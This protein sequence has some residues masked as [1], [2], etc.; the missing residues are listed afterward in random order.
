MNFILNQ[1]L[2][3]FLLII[4]SLAILYFFW[5][6]RE[7]L[8]KIKNATSDI[9]DVLLQWRNASDDL[10]KRDELNSD[11]KDSLI[12]FTHFET[13]KSLFSKK[14][15]LSHI[16][17][18]FDEQLT[19]SEEERC[20]KNSI[21]PYEFF[22]AEKISLN[23]DIDTH[24][25]DG[26][27]S[28]FIGIGIVGTFLGLTI[29]ILNLA[30]SFGQKDLNLVQDGLMRGVQGLLSGAGIAFFTSLLG[31]F[32]SLLFAH[33]KRNCFKD[34]D[35]AVYNLNKDIEKSLKFFTSEQLNEES[36]KSLKRQDKLLA[37]IDEHLNLKLDEAPNKI[38]EKLDPVFRQIQ[39]ALESLSQSGTQIIEKNTE[40]ATFKLEKLIETLSSSIERMSNQ[41]PKS[42]ESLLEGQK[43]F[44]IQINDSLKKI[45]SGTEESTVKMR[46]RFEQTNEAINN[47]VSQNQKEIY[48][49]MN[50]SLDKMLQSQK[51]INDDIVKVQQ[52][53]HLK[54]NESL[55]S[56]RESV[57]SL[58]LSVS[59]ITDLSDSLQ[60]KA[61]KEKQSL[62]QLIDLS[63][64]T[65]HGLQKIESLFKSLQSLS[66]ELENFSKEA[67]EYAS[68]L[69]V[70]NSK[71]TN[72]WGQYDARF[73]EIDQNLKRF[74]EEFSSGVQGTIEKT[75]ASFKEIQEGV[76][77]ICS[78]FAR[79]V[80][81]LKETIEELDSKTPSGT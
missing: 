63:Q 43:Q 13:I 75:H 21:R 1:P 5:E 10:K 34:F 57:N 41:A 11:F 8:K 35:K 72:S 17:D 73:G 76:K 29:G 47:N 22:N 49:R 45:L 6:S 53:A 56:L 71:I 28:K 26:A 48:N 74:M 61:D 40:G 65:E 16:W 55:S 80:D 69:D 4:I 77:N 20:Y 58:S 23:Y 31:M 78:T 70:A 19:K 18:E 54:S 64:K 79:A 44:G 30:L 3:I 51:S 50:S 60:Q 66:S 62:S 38:A 32:F 37:N 42:I 67:S 52:E 33:C 39:K 7:E 36:L 68:R 24:F 12:F 27:S 14:E 25:I 15:N 9:N 46:E 2:P 81:D 59:Q